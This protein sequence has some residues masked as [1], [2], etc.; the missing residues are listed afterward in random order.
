MV[1]VKS[2]DCALP[3]RE[4][5]PDHPRSSRKEPS[6]LAWPDQTQTS[7]VNLDFGKTINTFFRVSTSQIFHGAFLY[8]KHL[9]TVDLKFKLTDHPVLYFKWITYKGQLY[10]YT[11]IHTTWSS[12][13]CYEAVWMGGRFGGGWIHVHVWLSSFTVHLTLSQHC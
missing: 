1:L 6:R 8:Q 4:M 10:T 5:L 13:Q 2:W 3:A 11:Y 12:A 9:F 7:P